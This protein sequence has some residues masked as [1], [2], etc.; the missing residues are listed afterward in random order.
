MHRIHWITRAEETPF[1]L[2]DDDLCFSSSRQLSYKLTFCI[3]VMIGVFFMMTYATNSISTDLVTIDKPITVTT[4]DQVIEGKIPTTYAKVMP[5]LERFRRVRHLVARSG[6]FSMNSFPMELTPSAAL[7]F[8]DDILN[9]KM[10]IIARLL[11]CL[12]TAL[13]FDGLS[14]WPKNR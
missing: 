13:A 5:E 3:S 4:Y 12:T 8:K 11:V 9:Q 14:G 10:V 1:L 7:Q 2:L 6:S